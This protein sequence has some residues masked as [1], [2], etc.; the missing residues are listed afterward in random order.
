MDRGAG[1]SKAVLSVLPGIACT[2]LIRNWPK[3]SRWPGLLA[4]TTRGGAS[5]PEKSAS[6]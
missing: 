6:R 5:C 2:D 4:E 1:C 3:R